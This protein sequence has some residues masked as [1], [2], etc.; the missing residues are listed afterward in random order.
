MKMLVKLM[1]AALALL[2]FMVKNASGHT[3]KRQTIKIQTAHPFEPFEL[4]FI[5][6]VHRRMIPEFALP[7]AVDAVLIGGDFAEKGVP[8][9]RIEA[10]LKNLAKI[11]PVFFVWGNNDREVS[12][13]KLRKLLAK[14]GVTVLDNKGVPLFGNSHL[15]LVGVD[16]F[17]T[18]EVDFDKAFKNVGKEDAVIFVSHTPFVFKRVKKEYRADFLLAGH[19]HGGQIR[20]GRFGIYKKGT[21][22]RKNGTLQLVTNGYG[23]TKVPLRLGTKAEFHL[24]SI[25]PDRKR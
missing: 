25:R 7:L 23:T 17:P 8:F 12:E 16:F 2:L 4:L 18:E 20:F 1:A 11:G 22:I 10:N 3:M 15:K 21:L 19:T 6:D 14:Y 9:K 13:S 24:L 5:A